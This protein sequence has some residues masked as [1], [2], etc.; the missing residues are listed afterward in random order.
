MS[1]LWEKERKAK[2]FPFAATD[3]EEKLKFSITSGEA[4]WEDTLSFV[5]DS[6]SHELGNVKIK[7]ITVFGR[8]MKD[9]FSENNITHIDYMSMDVEG[10]EIYALKGID[11]D[12]VRINIITLENNL[13]KFARYGDPVIQKYLKSKGF[14]LYARIR[15]LDDIYV[16]KDFKY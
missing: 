9:V 16:H 4:G 13:S 11:F 7:E 1:T 5:T 2:F 12:K 3:T 6:L 10:H 8:P 14:K 15:G